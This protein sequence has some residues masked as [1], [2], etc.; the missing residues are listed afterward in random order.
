MGRP[1]RRDPTTSAAVSVGATEGTRGLVETI[2]SHARGRGSDVALVFT[3]GG[4]ERTVLTY[5]AL[6]ARACAIAGRLVQACPGGGHV[7]LPMTSDPLSVVALLGCLYAGLACAPVPVPNGEAGARRLNTLAASPTCAALAA[8]RKFLPRL[9]AVDAKLVVFDEQTGLDHH[10]SPANVQGE[11]L[12]FIQYTSGSGSDPKGVMLTHANVVAN[13]EMLRHSFGV[14]SE[15]SF[16]SW[17]PLFHDMGLAMLLMPLYFGC[18]GILMPPTSFIRDPARWFDVMSTNG[19]TITGAPNFAYDVS[20]RRV[21][22]ATIRGLDLSRL[23]L[24]FNGAEPVRGSSMKFFSERFA[25]AG[26]QSAAFF[27]CY[28]LAEAV[29]FVAGAHFDDV[30]LT[31][32]ED[33]S[34]FGQSIH[35][36]RPA[37]G[38]T[39]AIA[40]A[41]LKSLPDGN[42][43]EICVAGPHVG[44]GYLDRPDITN[45]TFGISLEGHHEL[46]FLRTGDLGFIREGCLTITG[47]LKDVIV[48]RGVNLHA[49]DVENIVA[50]S[51]PSLGEAVAFALEQ[52]GTEGVMVVQEISRG[53]VIDDPWSVLRAAEEAMA[54]HCGVRPL[55]V[56]LVRAGAIPRTTSGKVRR[57]SAR[58][59]YEEGLL[60]VVHS[61]RDTRRCHLSC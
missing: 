42:V 54:L 52:G 51:H 14:L 20:A 28:G 60:D 48:H 59:L 40:D 45:E 3:S 12:A 53:A 26:F 7:L 2:R 32:L 13:L 23:R 57:N 25:E 6:D 9:A 35:S 36:G 16:A 18:Q 39:I 15:D 44:L 43:G 10:Y 30:D 49:I 22:A 21:P 47:R 41:A 34:A 50:S 38:T 55:D 11:C 27:P 31:G 24:A 1:L 37:A 29:T 56:V 8:P 17:L 33:R 46:R 19:T 61:L 4:P 5:Q 58:R